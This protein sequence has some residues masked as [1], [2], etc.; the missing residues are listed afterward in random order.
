MP[1][2]ALFNNLPPQSL[3][4][5]ISD[6]ITSANGTAAVVT[7]A[8]GHATSG[9]ATFVNG[10]R[11]VSPNTTVA[12][13]GFWMVDK[14]IQSFT[15]EVRLTRDLFPGNALTVG[16]YLASYSSD[17]TW[18][19]GNNM[20]I[21]A[22][23]NAQLI[24]LV[25]KGAPKD[26]QVTNNGLLSGAFYALVDNFNGLN[27]AAFLSDQ[28][29]IG[30]WLLDG[31]VRLEWETINGTIENDSNVDL[32]SNPLTLY[33]NKT[34][35]AGGGWIPYNFGSRVPS[36]S[37]GVNYEFSSQMSVFGRANQ[38]YHLPSF[39]DLRNGQPESQHIT[40]VE[41]GTRAQTGT[42]YGVI[43]LFHRV[44]N[45]VPYQQFLAN[46]TSLTLEY[47]AHSTG[48]EFEGR[49]D[50]IAHLS[51]SLSGDWQHA[52]YTNG[53]GFTGNELQR[54]PKIQLRFTP[55]YKTPL[56]WGSLQ[57]FTTYSYIGQ[58]YSDIGNTQVLPTYYT[59]DAGAVADIDKSFEIRLQGSNLTNE[60]G[61][62][63]G[64]ARVTTSGISNGFEMARPIF[65]REVQVVLKYKF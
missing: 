8:G 60:L 59:L 5:F 19:L 17:D 22:T 54:Q 42:V 55:A 6:Q 16:A 33:N 36:W 43:D 58:R 57:L 3:S 52:T 40:S 29:R 45:G 14:K 11:A 10:G 26:I 47:G 1:T 2:N 13:V 48:L 30:P 49:W 61:L 50:P 20:L 7:A 56:A 38:G 62:T 21:T 41:I 23:P 24:N 63:E 53:S 18:Y 31:G 25:L 15:D 39:D 9:L 28:W 64:N 34:N 65:G 32:D 46:G 12:S 35:V 44:F 4:S 37:L 27:K 51:F